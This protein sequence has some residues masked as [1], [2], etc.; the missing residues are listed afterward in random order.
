M[1]VCLISGEFRPMQGG[2]G[3]F[4]YEVGWALRYLGA[5]VTVLTSTAA[6][7]PRDADGLRVEPRLERWGWNSWRT[8]M[9]TAEELEADVL[10]IQYQAAAYGMHPAINFLPLRLRARKQRPRVVVTFHDLKVPYLFPKA[11]RIRWWV[12]LALARWSDAVIV[13]NQEDLATLAPYPLSPAPYLIP[14]GSNIEPAPPADYD[15]DA[16]RA[17]W[18]VGPEDILLSYFGFLNESKGG[19]NLMR[20]LDKVVKKGYLARLLMVGGKWG[21]SDPSN[22]AYAQRVEALI[23][24]LGLSE[25]VMWT[26]YTPQEEV[27]ANLLASDICV[28]PYRDGASF[29][30]GSFMAALIHGLPIVTTHCA[31]LPKS[32]RLRKSV[33]S[34]RLPSLQ[35]GKNVLLVP[36]DDAALLAEAIARLADTPELRQKLGQGA[37]ELSKAFGWDHIA[38][39]TLEVYHAI[40]AG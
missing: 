28:L 26:G 38:E 39:K 10:N 2:V 17:R 7:P 19:E 24:E 9:R 11:G 40:C 15:R 23:D 13:T 4:T 22:V 35:D 21:S 14:I 34:Q 32:G 8:I 27:S 1:K 30:R 36:P 18:D 31:R 12:V 33:V 29:R 20:A 6:G 25:R 16:W 5:A 37:K 3:D